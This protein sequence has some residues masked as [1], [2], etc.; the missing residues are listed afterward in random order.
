LSISRK[1]S[2]RKEKGEGKNKPERKRKER[3]QTSV[4]G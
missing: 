1:Y 2:T 4:A 3:G